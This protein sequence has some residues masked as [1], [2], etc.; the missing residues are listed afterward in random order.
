MNGYHAA[1][2]QVRWKAIFV[3]PLHFKS[4]GMAK[5]PSPITCSLRWILPGA[6]GADLCVRPKFN[7][8]KHCEPVWIFLSTRCMSVVITHKLIFSKMS[9]R[10]S[11]FFKTSPRSI[12]ENSTTENTLLGFFLRINR[13]RQD[14]EFLAFLYNGNMWWP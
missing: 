10:G 2:K 12:T 3:Q 6:V 9:V 8:F 5:L 14:R 11:H 4:S 7:Y 13:E 1:K